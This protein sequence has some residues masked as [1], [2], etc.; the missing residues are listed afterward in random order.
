MENPGVFEPVDTQ[1][2]AP[3]K[4]PFAAGS[5]FDK[6][7]FYPPS[8]VI[9]GTNENRVSLEKFHA[10]SSREAKNISSD[11]D[12]ALAE[13]ALYEQNLAAYQQKVKEYYGTADGTPIAPG[14]NRVSPDMALGITEPTR[15]AY[16]SWLTSK[17]SNKDQIISNILNDAERANF[18]T[19][20]LMSEGVMD[21]VK[22]DPNAPRDQEYFTNILEKKGLLTKQEREFYLKGNNKYSRIFRTDINSRIWEA[23]KLRGLVKDEVPMNFSERLNSGVPLNPESKEDLE[24]FKFSKK[25]ARSPGFHEYVNNSAVAFSHLF[26]KVMDFLPDSIDSLVHP[27]YTWTDR[28]RNPSGEDANIKQQFVFELNRLIE[29]KKSSGAR[30]RDFPSALKNFKEVHGG[31]SEPDTLRMYLDD[32]DPTSKM[33][34]DEQSKKVVKLWAQ[35]RD[36]DAFSGADNPFAAGGQ[37]VL[38][39]AFS[40]A[41]GILVATAGLSYLVTSTDP[42]SVITE[43]IGSQFI[44]GQDELRFAMGA[45]TWEDVELK[46]QMRYI[47]AIQSMREGI[48]YVAREGLFT[49]VSGAGSEKVRE[50][51][52]AF[53]DV[54]T[55]KAIYK[56]F[57][58]LVGFGGVETMKDAAQGVAR[59][60]AIRARAMVADMVRKGASLPPE[61]RILV[62]EVKANSRAA[63]MVIDD[64]EAIERVISGRAKWV[65]PVTRKL[66]DIPANVI[67]DLK[68]SITDKSNGVARIRRKLAEVKKEGRNIQYSDKSVSTLRLVRQRLAEIEPGLWDKASNFEIYQRVMSGTLNMPAGKKSAV[69]INEL[70]INSLKKEVGEHWRK[71]DDVGLAGSQNFEALENLLTSIP[72]RGITRTLSKAGHGIQRALDKTT[73]TID[74]FRMPTQ[75]EIAAIL[76]A[77]GDVDKAA[78]M[79]LTATSNN[80][81]AKWNE[82][83]K[84]WSIANLAGY[85]GYFFEYWADWQKQATLAGAESRSVSGLLRASYGEKLST[86]LAEYEKMYAGVQTGLNTKEEHAKLL[87]EIER[88]TALKQFASL[89]HG[90]TEHGIGAGVYAF[91]NTLSSSFVNEGMMWLGDTQ[92][93]GT[94]TGYSFGSK[95]LNVVNRSFIRNVSPTQ[96]MNERTV[97]D[98][99]EISARMKEM[100]PSQ[101]ATIR[102]MIDVLVQRRE[103]K[104]NAPGSILM[105]ANQNILAQKEFAFYMNVINRVLM[106]TN[107]EFHD[108][109][110]VSGAIALYGS[111]EFASPEM[112]EKVKDLYLKQANE[113]GLN[114]LEAEAH[115]KKM[116]DLHRASIASESG[117][118]DIDVKIGKLKEELKFLEEDGKNRLKSHQE[119]MELLANEAGVNPDSLELTS[120][121]VIVNSKDSKG[122][123]VDITSNLSSATIKKI[124]AFQDT[125]VQFSKDIAENKSMVS[126]IN[127]QISQLEQQRA[128][129]VPN[130]SAERSARIG[131]YT[132]LD[133]GL[134]IER[135]EGVTLFHIPTDDGFGN[136][137]SKT[138]I[139]IDKDAFLRPGSLKQ[140]PGIAIAIEELAHALFMSDVLASNR[141]TFMRHFLGKWELNEHNQWEMKEAPSMAKT[142]EQAIMFLDKYAQAYAEGLGEVQGPLFLAKWELGKEKWKLNKAD[143]RFMTDVF[144]ELWG[145]IYQMRQLV[146]NPQAAKTG[147]T[148]QSYRGTWETSPIVAGTGNFKKFFKLTFGQTT[149]NDMITQDDMNN[150]LAFYSREIDESKMTHEEV[151]ARKNEIAEL[152]QKIAGS[153]MWV[154]TFVIGGTLDKMTRG[155]M[156]GLMRKFGFKVNNNESL[157]PT[158]LFSTTELWDEVTGKYAP[159]HPSVQATVDAAHSMT[160]GQPSHVTMNDNFIYDMIHQ[161]ENTNTPE[162]R[163]R[164]ILWA[165][166]TGRKEWLGKDGKFKAPISQL[167]FEEAKPIETFKNVVVDTDSN[168]QIY[169]LLPFKNKKGTIVLSGT[170]SKEQ[171]QR[172]IEWLRTTGDYG[173][174]S[175]FRMNQHHFDVI[176]KCL[177]GIGRSDILD[178]ENVKNKTAG[179]IPIFYMDY[180]GV[181][182]MTDG[183]KVVRGHTGLRR[184]A[185]FSVVIDK[186]TLDAEGFK[187]KKKNEKGYLTNSNLAPQDMMYFWAIDV[188]AWDARSKDGWEGNLKDVNDNRYQWTNAQ[189]KEWFGNYNTL[190][191]AQEKVLLN[192]TAGGP[193]AGKSTRF[194]PQRTWQ[195][196]LP[197]ANGNQKV[198]MKMA[199][200]ILRIIGFPD[201]QLG[202]LM[203]LEETEAKKLSSEE[204]ARLKELREKIAENPRGEAE[205]FF[206]RLQ[207]KDPNEFGAGPAFNAK[208]IFTKFRPDRVLG[209][210]GRVLTKEGDPAMLGFTANAYSWGKANYSTGSSWFNIT[211]REITT[212][213]AQYNM[214]EDRVLSGARH[215]SGY[216]TWLVE[217]SNPAFMVKEQ[218]WIVFDPERRRVTGEFKL[219]ADAEKAASDHS[220]ANPLSNSPQI[221]NAFEATMDE[222][223][224]SPVG[225]TFVNARRTEYI[226]KDGVWTVKR[227]DNGTFNLIDTKSGLTIRTNMSLRGSKKAGADTDVLLANIKDAIE[228]NSV[229]IAVTNERYRGLTESGIMEW[230]TVT[231]KDGTTKKQFAENNPVYWAFK[232]HLR[233][234]GDA[235]WANEITQMMIK[236]LG[237]DVVQTSPSKTIAWIQDFRSK[238]YFGSYL[239]KKLISPGLKTFKEMRAEERDAAQRTNAPVDPQP[240]RTP[241]QKPAHYTN[242]EWIAMLAEIDAAKVDYNAWEEGNTEH[243]QLVARHR[244][245]LELALKWS[246]NLMNDY[247]LFIEREKHGPAPTMNKA[248]EA[249]HFA[250]THAQTISALRKAGV[251]T[252]NIIRISDFGHVIAQI[253]PRDV[254]DLAG[255]RV[256][257]PSISGTIANT[258]TGKATKYRPNL[259]YLYSPKGLLIGQYKTFEDANNA[260]LEDVL[261]SRSIEAVKSKEKLK[262]IEG[263]RSK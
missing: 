3:A 102:D 35:L 22:E 75:G 259:F 32:R 127:E 222:A 58:K 105:R 148:P 129:L 254:L 196:L 221:G 255:T 227:A 64:Y 99:M 53:M 42:N 39:T 7:A 68:K 236:E 184:F 28:F 78:S 51:A 98:L 182:H 20:R 151:E 188:D 258:L 19:E 201:D 261:K 104:V 81:A 108:G 120:A 138:Q 94:A 55:A 172:L 149:I 4:E 61:A 40:I 181:T 187:L 211:N 218:R 90:L 231:T 123:K 103:D 177:D 69:E 87:A 257:F 24:L 155:A 36:R 111:K 216:S 178:A 84:I 65:N 5:T 141:T 237:E 262:E 246:D 219:R 132:T 159:I 165:F 134:V 54:W 157:D 215:P 97:Y 71:F 43:T 16:G 223:G 100:D 241:K 125:W 168:G 114:G 229:E 160:R 203:R 253:A 146:S 234:V 37:N 11:I 1:K 214:G 163:Q 44:D 31:T 217:R 38:G 164:R 230:K 162:A 195:V 109:S 76:S 226:S 41:D 152:E 8:Y 92:M 63:G 130:I 21:I 233:N 115:A 119:V 25:N 136:M 140:K 210:I 62:D 73:S 86:K 13:K 121:G 77:S 131:E 208:M 147:S 10:S 228:T 244:Q 56:N 145:K 192:F 173:S 166:S 137:V 26:E 174:S 112:A 191:E 176:A 153:N 72:S 128:S 110:V 82:A 143:T 18:I 45:M 169:G 175:P 207:A 101:A 180:A 197:Y 242:E 95:A 204:K 23:A 238:G 116:V 122:N 250:E 117:V 107:S 225:T 170:P 186:T 179:Y 67:E 249:A 199:D 158:K 52:A 240:P 79:N 224:F 48:G 248:M 150:A 91:G 205:Q 260:S 83:R 9:P 193:Y 247:R 251:A 198:A 263:W 88:L 59:E 49:Q 27:D 124:K 29:M 34:F 93:L 113:L 189:M 89:A 206:A 106:G 12:G 133:N 15:S 220:N 235:A 60:E 30:G 154:D 14:A 185:P 118:A 171:S 190:I 167:F 2:P 142:P 183:G 17:G 85:A 252:E 126:S 245:S 209:P 161:E 202:E 46:A 47:N 33:S 194:P 212:L 57:G 96:G 232:K 200:V 80:W 139:L 243:A 50:D 66:E 74:R 135:R 70:M 6:R 256:K 239:D 213:S 144:L 156:M